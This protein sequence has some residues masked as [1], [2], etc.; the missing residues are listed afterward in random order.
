MKL[1]RY[2]TA[3][4]EKPGVIDAQGRLRDLS[5]VIADITPHTLAPASL[6]KLAKVRMATLP[7]VRGSKR[8]GPPVAGV[9]KFIAIGLNYSDHAAEAGLPV[10]K[11][12]VVFTKAISCIQGANDPVM[13]PK[14]S[15]KSDWEVELGVV[16]GSTARYVS[17]REATFRKEWERQRQNPGSPAP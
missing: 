14:D 4:K 17:E 6:A 13:L 8:F 15:V 9:P 10:P 11:E 1:V 12:P 16:I 5:A 3:G 7:L 2:G